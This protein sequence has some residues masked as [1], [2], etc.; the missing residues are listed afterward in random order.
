MRPP[1]GTTPGTTPVRLA[2]G[3]RSRSAKRLLCLV[4]ARRRAL[5][6]PVALDKSPGTV[7]GAVRGR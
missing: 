7:C 1:G 6:A 5:L 4:A 3:Q 2:L